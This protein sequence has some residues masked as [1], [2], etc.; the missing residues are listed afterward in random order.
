MKKIVIKPLKELFS[1][2][3]IQGL[4]DNL[5]AVWCWLY[6]YRVEKNV[7]IEVNCYLEDIY[8]S[9]DNGIKGEV[10]D[11]FMA[12]LGRKQRHNPILI[13]KDAYIGIN[14]L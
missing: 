1:A 4:F 3:I 2:I 8:L 12:C 11:V 5:R 14:A 6:D 9:F 13:K 7:F 10:M